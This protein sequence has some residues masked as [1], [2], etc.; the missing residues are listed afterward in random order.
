MDII[1]RFI[2][3]RIA[4]EAVRPFWS[5][6]VVYSLVIVAGLG[7]SMALA[8]FGA[9]DS[10]HGIGSFSEIVFWVA[11]AVPWVLAP[12]IRLPARRVFGLTHAP[13]FWFI[14]PGNL[15]RALGKVRW[16][17]PARE[18]PTWQWS[19]RHYALSSYANALAMGAAMAITATIGLWLDNP[20]SPDWY[21]MGN[22]GAMIG[23]WLLILLWNVFYGTGPNALIHDEE[24]TTALSPP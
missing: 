19:G 9:L 13:A 22:A 12:A 16:S 3:N 15:W 18:V 11:L 8:A 20:A 17:R 24:D 6:V 1:S 21:A 4:P 14:P 5:E 10:V 23:F 7:V 2:A